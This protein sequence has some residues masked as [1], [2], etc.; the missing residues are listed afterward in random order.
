MYL[1]NPLVTIKTIK[2][3]SALTEPH[4]IYKRYCLL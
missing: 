2:W 1:F 4:F 3:G